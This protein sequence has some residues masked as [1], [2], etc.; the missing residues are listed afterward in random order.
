M[1]RGSL[2]RKR[3]RR[4]GSLRSAKSRPSARSM[5]STIST[6]RSPMLKAENIERVTTAPPRQAPNQK[7]KRKAGDPLPFFTTRDLHGEY[8]PSPYIVKH[9][10]DPSD[11]LN[12][13]GDSGALKTF[14]V[15]DMLMHVA[16]GVN[17]CGHRVQRTG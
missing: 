17:Y 3:A 1:P 6:T 15:L 10:L 8:R 2:H 7:P 9:M 13:F 11:W 5:P 14:F 4:A 16:S 12:V